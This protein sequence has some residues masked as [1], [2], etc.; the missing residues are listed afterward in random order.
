MSF[1]TGKNFSVATGFTPG[2]NFDLNRN[3]LTGAI[4]ATL[5]GVSGSFSGHVP[6]EPGHFTPGMDFVAVDQY[7]FGPDFS[8]VPFLPSGVI[9]GILSGLSGSL[10]AHYQVPPTVGV[11]SAELSGLTGSLTAHIP[12]AGLVQGELQ[13]ISGAVTGHNAATS[14][15]INVTLSGLSGSITAVYDPNVHR[16]TL[17]STTSVQQDTGSASL[18]AAFY[19]QQAKPFGVIAHAEQQNAIPL[20]LDSAIVVNATIP[21][22]LERCIIAEESTSLTS[23]IQVP[24]EALQQLNIKRCG[25]VDEATPLF[26]SL[27]AGFDLLEFIRSGT[28]H[29]VDDTAPTVHETTHEID[30]WAPFATSRTAGTDFVV[31]DGFTVGTRFSGPFLGAVVYR[32]VIQTGGVRHGAASHWQS[33]T[34]YSKRQ[35]STVQDAR[36]PLP[37]TSVPVDPPRPPP[38]V[39]PGHQTHTIPTKTAYLMQHTLS[40]TLLDLT[41]V[42]MQSVSLSLDADSFAWQFKGTLLSQD[43][44]AL[45]QQVNGEPVQLIITING[46]VWKVLVERIEHSRQFGTRSITLSGRGLTALLGQPYEQPAS[47]T[48]GSLLTVQ[49]IAELH[50]PIGWTLNWQTVVWNIPAGAYSYTNQTPIQALGSLASDIG[51]MLVPSRAAQSLTVKPR[52]PVLPWDFFDVPADVVI[53]ESALANLTQRPVVPYQA[54]SVYVHGGEVGGVIGWCRFNGTAGDRLAPTVSNALI[55]DVIGAR[56][57]GERILA[58]QYTQPAIQSATLPMDGGDFP[59]LDVGQLAQI[60]VDGSPVRGIVNSVSID[61]SLASVR[62]TIQIGE[63]TPNTWA[64][65]KELLPRDPLLFANLVETDGTTSLMSLLD[66]GVVRVRGTGTVDNAYYIRA[67][68]ID[69]EAPSMVQSEI[70]I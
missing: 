63:E 30:T 33:A 59:L 8:F 15:H 61:A 36:R 7:T 51:A 27:R 68:K 62:Q 37:G 6:V 39:D 1:T 42:P 9:N 11:L 43:G 20:A 31:N 16:Y 10:T 47:A 57:I 14:G 3:T 34:P 66:N 38:V 17:I 49:Q 44:L 64:I 18:K 19:V 2:N 69:G 26:C 65:F 21:A 32:D 25:T 48:Q 29:P 5:S 22:M 67:G 46:Y 23:A 54:N 56:A 28:V 4:S 52:Y 55:T 13:G 35:C 50:L 12:T 53:P 41:P 45:V 24:I 60:T 40:V 58:G 70:V